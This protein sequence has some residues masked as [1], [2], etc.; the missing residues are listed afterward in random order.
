M[1]GQKVIFYQSCRLIVKR[2]EFL[3]NLSIRTKLFLI[4]VIP[5][6]GLIFF[7]YSAISN[8][9]DRKNATLRVYQECEEVD[10]LSAVL[11]ELQRERAFYISYLSSKSEQDLLR[12]REQIPATSRAI[13]NLQEI[14]REHNR[15]SG[16]FLVLDSLS[17]FR[18]ELSSYP[19]ALNLVKSR[20]LDEVF[21]ISK[22]S[23]SPIVKDQLQSHLF[24]LFTKEYFA[25]ARNIL[26]PFFIEKTLTRNELAHFAE[27]RGQ[28]E[29]SRSKFTLNASN[30]LLKSYNRAFAAEDIREVHGVFDAMLTDPK[31]VVDITATDWSMRSMVVIDAQV[32]IEQLSL[33][34]I[35]ETAATEIEAI[36]TTLRANALAGGLALLLAAAL[37]AFTIR[38][39]V[40][41]IAELK[42][43]AKKLALG[44]VDFAVNV[45][46]RDE[47]GDLAESFNKMV[48]VKKL[49]ADTA[50]RIG[51]GKYDTPVLVRTNADI[52][53]LAL[54]NMKDS[55]ERLSRE[56]EVR[57]WMLTGNGQLD[58]KMRGEKDLTV[59]A[60]DVIGQL[61]Q[62]LN[63]QIGALYVRENG[64]LKR[65]GRYA[66]DPDS[67]AANI[68][69]GQGLVGQVAADGKEIL[70]KNVPDNYLK[71]HSSL[72][73]LR[74]RNVIVYPFRYEG[75]VRGVLEL[76]ATKEF[77]DL[78]VEFLQ[79]VSS[80]IGI[81]INAAQARERMKE[82]LEETQRQS[83]EL[84]AKQ[85]EL[86]QFNEE[87]IEKTHLLEKSGE[88]LKT[89]QEELQMSNEE[90]VEKAVMLEEQTKNLEY[91][92]SQMEAK[93][94]E[95][96]LAS[97][98]KS[99]F[100]SNM[101]HELR[102]PLNSILILAQ[103]L[104]EN[105]NNSLSQKEVKVASTIHQSGNDLLNLINEIL[106]LSKIEA[107]KMDLDIE[108]FAIDILI[109]KLKNSFEEVA[110]SKKVRFE[111]KCEEEVRQTILIT[112]E[113]RV[114]Q[115]VRNF[116]SN[117]LKFTPSGGRVSLAISKTAPEITFASEALRN[118]PTVI[119]FEVSDTGIGIPAEKLDMIFHAFQQGDGSTKRQYGGTGLGLSIS[120]ELATLLRGEIQVTSRPGAGSTFT[121]FLPLEIS[122]GAVTRED[123]VISIQPIKT[124]IEALAIAEEI[125]FVDAA[126]YDDQHLLTPGDRKILIMEDDVEFS[127]V[128]LDFVHERNYKGI[129]AHQGNTGLSYARHY[130]P[131]AIILDMNLPVVD[132]S[133]V[134]KNLKID[135]DLR[136]IPVQIISGLDFRKRGLELGAI[137]FLHKPVTK[138][139]FWKALDK[140]E[141]F[142]SRKPKKLLIIEDDQL[143]NAAVRELIGNGDVKCYSAYSGREAM[144]MLSTTSFDCI[145]VD[146]GLP[147]MSGFSFLEQ[148]RESAKVNRIPVIVYTGKDLTK[149]QNAALEK[150]A[151]TVVLKTAFSHERLLDETSLFLH[152][153]ESKLP[154]EKQQ[155]IRK[156][157]KTDEVLRN[158][159]AL[160]V[161]D[162]DRNVYSLVTALEAEGMNCINADNGKE[163]LN[164]LT[165]GQGRK[166]DIV[167][168]DVM[169]PE[170]DGFEA[171]KLIRRM[172]HY[173]KVPI[174]ALTAKAMRDDREKCLAAGMSDYIS[175]PVNLPQLLSLMRVWLYA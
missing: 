66:F 90:L 99:D 49:Y 135:P 24:L 107:G 100:L 70:L 76:G 82:L 15:S 94:K 96:E 13:E 88:E 111:I 148:I 164:L 35:R 31:D 83:E 133:Q 33:R 175:K 157:H 124:N 125:P 169:M 145:I 146:L 62:F 151:N 117:A 3:K 18:N 84:E 101:S 53:G 91:T 61:G 112:D 68:P 21:Y 19:D 92:R 142:V 163:A 69:L 167:L 44:E 116:L 143:H 64:H 43:A 26:L 109:G 149:E 77:T 144:N 103:V 127:K 123:N 136:H 97:Q 122:S 29:L 115:V 130:R 25:R 138:E 80:R 28:Y 56:N 118:S 126:H 161:D 5:S 89:Q 166:I 95:L 81:A 165:E 154:K 73:S 114:E 52:L 131:D 134:L 139:G 156:L 4:S 108:S 12:I 86:K 36:N 140:V 72:G 51:E 147:D 2:M 10:R 16:L 128:L 8:S 57:T 45:N 159:C 78:E 152:R 46:S 170:V 47:L 85:E 153:V 9:V 27:V 174:I 120:R 67:Q 162:D 41:S 141:H 150:L 75:E 34:Q 79:T 38:H 87:L 93:A 48:S 129:I 65:S 17:G 98:Y 40:A 58:D 59:L 60:D 71:V 106:D 1:H 105:R 137:D 22:R 50:A 121:L 55:L 11:H 168:M 173:K 104:M 37:V 7:L 74:P 155:I 113:Q 39:I 63:A 172:P 23:E 119:A 6:L 42:D 14:Y 110:K 102:T 30:D 54:T 32:E 20:V 158:K 132:G 160:I 171:T